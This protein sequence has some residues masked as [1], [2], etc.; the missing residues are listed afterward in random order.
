M[1]ATISL[2]VVKKFQVLF[3]WCTQLIL[4]QVQFVSGSFIASASFN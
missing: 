4:G 1:D 3:L 2:L